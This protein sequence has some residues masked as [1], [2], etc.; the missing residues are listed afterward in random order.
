MAAW[1]SLTMKLLDYE[2]LADKGIKFSDTHIGRLIS[3]KQ[4]PKPVKIGKRSYWVEAEI[5]QY[6][7]DK[8]A[9]RDSAAA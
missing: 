7:S 6:I 5:D 4:F 1:R 2:G 3:K 8:L 9:Q